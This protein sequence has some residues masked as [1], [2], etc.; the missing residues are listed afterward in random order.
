MGLPKNKNGIYNALTR[1]PPATFDKLLSRVNEYARVEDDEV[2]EQ[3]STPAKAKVNNVGT[4]GNGGKFDK[5]K[6][7]RRED[8]S[9]VGSDGFKGIN[10]VFNKPIHKIMFDIRDQPFFEWPRQMG[11]DPN[12]RNKKL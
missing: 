8:N 6:R 3:E 4:S 9:V 2:A 7:K 12:A 1:Q 10:T 11:G 5:N